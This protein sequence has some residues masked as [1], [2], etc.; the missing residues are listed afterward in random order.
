MTMATMLI[1]LM[2]MLSEGPDVSLN[3]SPGAQ[4]EMVFPSLLAIAVP[5]IVGLIFGVPGVV[6]LLVGWWISVR[7]GHSR[8]RRRR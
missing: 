1:S 3:G 2:R 4:R 7:S 6:G 8:A 5:I